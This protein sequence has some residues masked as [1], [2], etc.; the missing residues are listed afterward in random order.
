MAA[1]ILTRLI[2]QLKAKGHND[3]SARAIAVSALQRSGNLKPGTED[4]TPKG[5]RRGAMSPGE[6]AKD[7]ESRRTGRPRTDYKY[8]S[9]TNRATLIKK[10]HG[11]SHR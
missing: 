10:T 8:T 3:A 9:K 11:K 2:S 6:R 1:A 7:R 4:A 5:T